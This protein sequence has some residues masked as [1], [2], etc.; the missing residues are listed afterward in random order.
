MTLPTADSPEQAVRPHRLRFD[1][2]INIPTVLTLLTMIGVSIAS[3]LGIYSSLSD[4][5]NINASAIGLMQSEQV[6]QKS[7]ASQTRQ[8]MKGDLL[9][10]DGKLDR[11]LWDRGAQKNSA[12]DPAP[13]TYQ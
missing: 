9:R 12:P 8:D 11:L 10:M 7:Q 6:E 2:T 5:I 4:R 3:A 13:G 1:G